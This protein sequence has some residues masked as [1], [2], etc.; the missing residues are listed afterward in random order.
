MHKNDTTKV[1]IIY[2]VNFTYNCDYSY[3]RFNPE[4]SAETADV[5]QSAKYEFASSYTTRKTLAFEGLFCMET[6]AFSGR[7]KHH[8]S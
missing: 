7:T 5:S 6:S 3:K 1:N 4:V 8:F 2:R